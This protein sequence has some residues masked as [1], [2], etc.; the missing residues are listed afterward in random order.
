MSEPCDLQN[1]NSEFFSTGNEKVLALRKTLLEKW[2]KV[3]DGC[4]KIPLT[5]RDG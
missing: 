1:R 5:A 2:K 4:N 3:V